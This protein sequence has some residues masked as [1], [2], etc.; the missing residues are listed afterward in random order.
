MRKISVLILGLV[1]LSSCTDG[2]EILKIKKNYDFSYVS[3]WI[4]ESDI[5]SVWYIDWVSNVSLATKF[6]GK[7]TW[8]FVD[9]GDYVKKW[10]L[11]LELDSKE[12]KVWYGIS[13]DIIQ[14]LEEMKITTKKMFDEQL[15]V[16]NQ[17]LNQINIWNNNLEVSISDIKNIWEK[18]LKTSEVQI[19]TAEL[20]FLNTKKI[21]EQ[22]EKNIYE[23]SKS[24]ITSSI[25]LNTN[26]LI[27]IDELLWI[28]KSNKHKNDNIED[29]LSVKK[30]AYLKLAIDQ[31]N[32]TNDL[33]FEYKKLYLEKIEWKTVSNDDIILGLD[34]WEKIASQLKI[35]L[36]LT[37]QILDNSIENVYFT[38]NTIGNHKK[39]L[40]DFWIAVEQ[41]L[42]SVSWEYLVWLK[43]NKQSLNNFIKTKSNTIQLLSKKLELEK[44]NFDTISASSDSQIRLTESKYQISKS[45]K[46]EIKASIESI[47][48]QKQLKISEI[49]LKI[50][51]ANWSKNN[52]LVSLDWGK[53]Y[54][55]MNWII[56][57]KNVEIWQVVWWGQTLLNISNI[58]NF[59]IKTDINEKDFNDNIDQ[60]S[61]LLEI[62]WVDKQVVWT[63]SKVFSLKDKI[64]KKLLLEISFEN[65]FDNIKLWTYSKILF[66]NQNKSDTIIIPNSAIVSKFLIAW[67]YIIEWEKAV[68]KN[69]QIITQNNSFSE[70]KWLDVWV[71]IITTWKENII[72]GEK[73]N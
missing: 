35:L 67:V 24:S 3:T 33:F 22:K 11:L 69:I 29:Y 18:K 10:D 71:K 4:I 62:D 56:S 59:I 40:S 31:F 60:K 37:Y 6:W 5:S 58:E 55:S 28:T 9:E 17:K 61:V 47:K 72:D 41:N 52:S 42:L 48:K 23:N 20:N 39:Q 8:I 51:E 16:M 12:A 25:I 21:L 26:I 45:Q 57:Y 53:I 19:K 34:H 7:V 13:N 38:I 65:T 14:S 30:I 49:V 36:D 1:L 63:I 44:S 46:E 27:Y 73:L 70:I 50:Q 68:F 43:G 64:T 54:A 32:K 66:K 15:L 2:N